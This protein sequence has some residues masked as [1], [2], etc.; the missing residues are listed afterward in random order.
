MTLPKLL[1]FLCIIL[2]G[3][4][5]IAAIFKSSSTPV[6]TRPSNQIPLEI[7]LDQNIQVITPAL[8]V[9][10][11]SRSPDF[12]LST[13]ELPEANRIEELF[14]KD[15]KL[16]IVETI[17]YKS[18]VNWQKGRPAWLSDYAAHFETSRHFI[19]RS[20]NGKPDYLKQDLAEGE[21]FN[22]LCKDKNIQFYLIVD[23]SRCKMWFYYLADDEKKPVLI[24]TYPV[25][26]GRLDSSSSSGLLTPLGKYSLGDRIATYKPKSMGIY[27][28]KKTEMITV[29]GTRWIPFEQEIG[30]TTAPAKGFGIHGTPWEYQSGLAVDQID[31]V[32]K[33]QSDGCIRLTTPDMEELF[34]IIVTKPTTIEIVRD[35]SEATL[36]GILD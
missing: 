12:S 1:A 8:A 33:Y 13:L 14:V 24:K 20:L 19:A 9:A 30:H 6:S 10:Q 5:G 28:G 3:A 34:S 4:I 18:R 22:V 15:S 7:D 17:T 31:S 2:F 16:P 25:G 36:P 23:T 32:G 29:F 21:R 11:Q 26:L 35:F 27:Q